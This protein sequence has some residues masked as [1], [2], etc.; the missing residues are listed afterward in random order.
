MNLTLTVFR[1][2]SLYLHFLRQLPPEV[3]RISATT[4]AAELG[5]G[6]VMVR[7]EL[8]QI[9]AAAGRPKVGYE[10][11]AL[12]KALENFMG[13]GKLR[14]AVVIGAGK[15]GR[16]LMGYEGFTQYGLH[17]AAA[18]D[19]NENV[20]GVQESGRPILSMEDLP[21]FCRQQQVEIGIITVPA[22]QA[23][24]VCNRLCE[25]G[26]RAIWCFAPAALSVPE[27]VSVQYENMAASLAMLS[28]HLD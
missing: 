1:R 12:I 14:R 25:N 6:E 5:L 28:K 9:S 21:E 20:I 2:L 4:I 26:V 27:G 24:L 10:V 13:Y 19:I 7:K 8:S 17:I 16:A 11:S 22:T 3:T 18:F 15:L 23:Q